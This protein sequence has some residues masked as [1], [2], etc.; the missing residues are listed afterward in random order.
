VRTLL[1]ILSLASS[2]ADAYYT[3]RNFGPTFRERD[4][5]ARPFVRN[6]PSLVISSA[7][8]AALKIYVPHKLRK[9]HPNWA[10]STELA[11]ISLNTIGAIQSA[12]GHP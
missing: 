1:L 6:T 3:Q 2:G 4:P 11:G 12:Q 9:R 10:L 5:I 8:F 7:G